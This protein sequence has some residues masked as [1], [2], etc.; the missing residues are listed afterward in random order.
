[1]VKVDGF[2]LEE[3]KEGDDKDGAQIHSSEASAALPLSAAPRLWDARRAASP[4][5][6]FPVPVSAFD[7]VVNLLSSQTPPASVG[8][9]VSNDSALERHPP[10]P[11]KWTL[12][13]GPLV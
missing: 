13:A 10:S 11:P 3:R 5:A 1:M 8:A 12:Y 6:L 2:R 9:W 4:E 7:H